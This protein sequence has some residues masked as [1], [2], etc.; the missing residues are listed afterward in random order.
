MYA[1]KVKAPSKDVKK[2]H[3]LRYHS[4]HDNTYLG[5][6]S[7]HGAGHDG[8]DVREDGHVPE[9]GGGRDGRL[10]DLRT[11]QCN[12]KIGCATTP[13]VAYDQQGLIFAAACADGEVTLY[14]AR[15][16]ARGPFSA[17]KVGS[18]DRATGLRRA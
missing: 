16:Y 7:Q 10:W 4:L 11:D 6:S 1:S 3:A 12:G 14:D 18:V 17:G 9:R 2:D 5:T 15:G 13:C 8:V